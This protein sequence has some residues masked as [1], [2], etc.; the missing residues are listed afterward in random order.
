VT[1]E[2]DRRGS[3]VKVYL[4]DALSCKMRLHMQAHETGLEE[5]RPGRLKLEVRLKHG[6]GN[7]PEILP[8]PTRKRCKV[9]DDRRTSH[10]HA[11]STPRTRLI[12]LHSLRSKGVTAR[13]GVKKSLLGVS[14]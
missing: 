10:S 9:S 7:P 2:N 13:F 6:A 14:L 11:L 5:L 4:C 1:L 3:K 8:N 12:R